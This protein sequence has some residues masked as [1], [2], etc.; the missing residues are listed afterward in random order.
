MPARQSG[1][2]LCF[3]NALLSSVL[4]SLATSKQSTPSDDADK[5]LVRFQ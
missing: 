5:V 1:L 3:S 4:T 2:R